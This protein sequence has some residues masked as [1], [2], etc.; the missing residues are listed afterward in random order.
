M[1]PITIL[2]IIAVYFGVLLIISRISMRTLDN[3]GFFVGNRESPWWAVAIGM[4]GVSL[5]GVTFVSVPGWVISNDMTYMQVIFG[6]F[7]GYY[8]VSKVLLPIYYKEK[9]T[10]IY[11]LLE[12]RIGASSHQVGAVFFLLSKSIGAAAR[13][14]LITLVLHQLIGEPLGMAYWMTALAC[15]VLIWGYTH[16]GGIQTLVW[17]DILQTI[18]LIAALVLIIGTA[19]SKLGYSPMEAVQAVAESEHCRIFC[20]DWHSSQ[21]FV[22]QFLSGIFMV[23]VMTGIDQ[24]MMQKNLSCRSLPEAQRNMNCYSLAFLPCNLLFLALGVLLVILLQQQGLDLPA[25]GDTLLPGMISMGLLGH[26]AEILFVLGITAAAFSSADSAMTALTT[27]CCVD[28]LHSDRLPEE[29][30]SKVRQMMHIVVAIVML[31][32]ML[33]FNALNQKSMIDA[34]YTIAA[35]TYGPLLGLFSFALL[36]H[37]RV[38]AHWATLLIG[39]AIIPVVCYFIQGL[40]ARTVGYEMGYELLILSGALTYLY[41]TLLSYLNKHTSHAD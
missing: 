23:I 14:Y 17:S 40:L 31:G 11:T 36:A 8:F 33:S 2:L 12:R 39:C 10:S 27:S 35:Y 29:R 30:A 25:N 41:L 16:R 22:K 5:S 15:I 37:R 1:S 3:E 34:V 38:E 13:M 24:D 20:W 18:S 9:L 32:M 6:F 26:G 28:L 19:I 4:V 7:F 21:F